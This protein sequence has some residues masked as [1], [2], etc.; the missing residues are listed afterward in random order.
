MDEFGQSPDK[1][2]G[3]KTR[4]PERAAGPPYHKPGDT[5]TIPR[6][7]HTDRDRERQVA[8]KDDAGCCKC[9]IM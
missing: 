9:V 1:S 6:P 3:N 4:Q 2:E 8:E 5:M 7:M